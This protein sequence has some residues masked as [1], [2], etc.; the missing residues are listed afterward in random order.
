MTDREIIYQWVLAHFEP[1]ELDQLF[2]DGY[3]EM[4]AVIGFI[5]VDSTCGMTLNV[6]FGGVADGEVFRPLFKP[7]DF[8]QRFFVRYSLFAKKEMRLLSKQE[9]IEFNL[10]EFPD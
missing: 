7:A 10:P 2:G 5:Y 8:K 1:K 6:E 9:K 3:E 4:N